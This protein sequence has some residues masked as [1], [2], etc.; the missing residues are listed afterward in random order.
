MRRSHLLLG[1]LVLI[2]GAVAAFAL[3]RAP[4]RPPSIVL[5]TIDTARVDRFGCYGNRE[6]RTSP[7]PFADALAA[8]GVR[9]ENAFAPR[10]ETHPSLASLLTGKY[11]ATHGLRDNGAP[12]D[13]RHVPFP[14]LLQRAGYRTAAFAS[15]LDRTRWPFWL[16]GFDVAVDGVAGR[17]MDEGGAVQATSQRTW[18]ERVE[19]AVTSWIGSRSADDRPFFLWVHLYDAHD[20]YTPAAEDAARFV[21]ASYRG[22]ITNELP[23]DGVSEWLRRWT[24]GDA[25]PTDADSKQVRALYDAGLSGVDARLARIHAALESKRLLDGAVIVLTA[26]HGEE[27]GDHHRYFAHGASIYDTVLRV[28]LIAAAP[29]RFPAGR[30]VDALA[31]LHDLF[32]TILDLAGVD[33]PSDQEGFDLVPVL[34]G[35]AE[36]TARRHVIAEW[37]D[38]IFSASDGQWK[39]IKNPGGVRPRKPPYHLKEG[40]CFPLDCFALYHVA[41][42]PLERSNLYRKDDSHVADLTRV[43]DEFLRDARHS[44]PMARAGADPALAAIGYAGAGGAGSTGRDVIRIDCGENK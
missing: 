39:F 26:D 44:R 9:F 3:R 32:T 33:V 20:P 35:K 41:A 38:A 18:D 11:P 19:R 8:R 17:L 6:A 24:L 10:G 29:G 27:L 34:E 21:D 22:P 2:G 36:R 1:S 31:Q 16:R 5:F 7:T 13:A 40:A 42:D 4:A 15:N 12:L 37:E 43:L 28:P 23:R 25:A 14:V 30:R